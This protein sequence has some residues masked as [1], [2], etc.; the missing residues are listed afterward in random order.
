[1]N[2][3]FSKYAGIVRRVLDPTRAQI[4]EVL[5]YPEELERYLGSPE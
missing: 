5:E 2:P 1:M 3:N 4:Q